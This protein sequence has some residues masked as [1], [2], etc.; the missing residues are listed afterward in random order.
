MNTPLNLPAQPTAPSS[1]SRRRFLKT[2]ALGAATLGFPS[3][4]PSSAW[5]KVRRPSANS[6]I[7]IGVIGTGNQ[8]FNDI[9]SMI[10]DPRVQIVAVCDVNK[11]SAGYWNGAIG[12]REPGRKL[13]D[14]YYAS[15]TASGSYKGCD[16]YTDFRELLARG[17]IDAVQIVT[18]D[19]WHALQVIAACKAGKDVYC[20][21]P[22]SLTI[23]EGRAM[24]NAVKK[25][26]RVLQTGSQQRSD[27]DFRH[28]CELVRNG[29][30]GKLHTVRCGLPSGHPDLGKT[31][32]RKQPEPVPEG[33]NYDL[34][35]GPAPEAPY[36]P[37]RCHVNFRWNLDYSGGQLTDWGGHHPDIAQWG[38]GTERTG[39]LEI[40]NARGIYP[41]RTELWNTATEYSFECHYANGVRLIV[42]DK[43]EMGVTFEGS[44]GKIFVSRGQHRTEPAGLWESQITASETHLYAS[45][46]HFR[47]FIDCVLSRQEPIAP[48]E[49]AHRS[50]SIAHLGNI[51]MQLGRDLKWDPKRER[52]VNDDEANRKLLRPYRGSWKLA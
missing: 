52:F 4:V 40:R 16:T 27:K 50:I 34:W 1:Q 47:N 2:A 21:K 45:E 22:L 38:M 19:H 33:F 41:P 18:P 9:K 23:G 46:D 17:D 24:A 51:A 49:V 31:G 11:E 10:K 44:E 12:G 25:Y 13:V 30:I 5:G 37:A 8:G 7:Q 26:G 3:I 20:Q 36:A 43:N 48:C 42:S 14:G 29:R 15:K 35:L 6:R 32:H 28:A 39:P